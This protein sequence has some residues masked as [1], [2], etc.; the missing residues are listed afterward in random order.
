M[1]SHSSVRAIPVHGALI[2]IGLMHF[3]AQARNERP[4][5]RLFED[6]PPGKNGY[7]SHN[8]S[9]WFS[10]YLESIG[11]KG[12]KTVFHSL[13]HNFKDALIA[14]E[15]PEQ[16]AKILMGHADGSVHGIYGSKMSITAL[17]QS[18]QRIKFPIKIEH[19]YPLSAPVLNAN[20]L[21]NN[22]P[23]L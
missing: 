23:L 21:E 4:T 1:K 12:K 13:R 18:L 17:D 9:K 14:A 7:Y 3:V 2:K 6:I 10:R 22:D 16:T 8:F 11:G 15:V 5:G 19:L 20:S